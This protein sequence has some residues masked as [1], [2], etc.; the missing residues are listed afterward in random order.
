VSNAYYTKPVQT[1]NK[2]E[3]RGSEGKTDRTSEKGRSREDGGAM[4]GQTDEIHVIAAIRDLQLFC[5]NLLPK[6]LISLILFSI[7]RIHGFSCAFTEARNKA[8]K[9][10]GST[11]SNG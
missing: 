9:D 11:T 3:G 4:A 2:Y 6:T 5:L 1:G 7:H 8:Q 10:S